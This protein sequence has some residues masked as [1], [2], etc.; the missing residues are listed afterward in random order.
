MLQIRPNQISC[1]SIMGSHQLDLL[2]SGERRVF[3]C[4]QLEHADKAGL[5]TSQNDGNTRIQ[6]LHGYVLDIDHP[7]VRVIKRD[8]VQAGELR[9]ITDV[10]ALV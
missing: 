1:L 10:H 2:C 5:R 4:V 9:V 7:P 3:L 8:Q 6:T